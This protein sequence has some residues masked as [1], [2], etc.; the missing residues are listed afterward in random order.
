MGAHLKENLL[1]DYFNVSL[2]HA[3]M[4]QLGL[5]IC[6]QIFRSPADPEK[7]FDNIFSDIIATGKTPGAKFDIISFSEMN[8]VL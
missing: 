4:E 1:S 8:R 3:T 2:E 6:Y 7:R 5:A